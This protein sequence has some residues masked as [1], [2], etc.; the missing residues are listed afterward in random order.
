MEKV[1][2]VFGELKNPDG[3]MLCSSQLCPCKFE[4]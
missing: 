4:R 2:A 3:E 1:I